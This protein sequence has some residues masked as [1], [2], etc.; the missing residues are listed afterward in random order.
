MNSPG[1]SHENSGLKDGAVVLET[2]Y[3]PLHIKRKIGMVLVGLVIFAYGWSELWPPL[4]L[5]L[6]GHH[7]LGEATRVIK[8]KPGLPDQIFTDDVKLSAAQ[9][10][11]DR[12]YVFWN[13]F[14]FIAADNK[15]YVVRLDTGGQLKPLFPLLDADGLPATV[16]IYYDPKDPSKTCIPI[17]LS[18]WFAPALITF[19]GAVCSLFGCL[20]LYWAR[21]KIEIT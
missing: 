12:S 13:E 18:T 16:Q 14:K 5:V 3:T 10:S 15:E 1:L 2:H 17:L 19:M 4:S 7:A 11:R 8:A 6:S 20:I 21:H 9:E